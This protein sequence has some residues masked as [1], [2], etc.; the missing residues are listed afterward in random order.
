MKK[1]K[2]LESTIENLKE[3]FRK[4][5]N[6][7]RETLRDLGFVKVRCEYSYIFS[8]FTHKSLLMK[9]KNIISDKNEISPKIWLIIH[10][11]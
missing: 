7:I 2:E 4:K 10:K 11:P 9:K 5:E 6:E 3:A 8:S 1:N